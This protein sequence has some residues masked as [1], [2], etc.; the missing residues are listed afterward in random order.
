[1]MQR[2]MS[3]AARTV[4]PWDAHMHSF[5]KREFNPVATQ[6][7]VTEQDIDNFFNELRKSPNYKPK[8][9]VCLVLM[10]PLIMV[11]GMVVM[12][13]LIFSSASS[14]SSSSGPSSTIFL[15]FLMMPLMF[16]CMIGIICYA[17]QTRMKG[18]KNRQLEFEQICNVQNQSYFKAKECRW[19]CGR[20]GAYLTLELDFVARGL[21]QM[22][23]PGGFNPMMN[24]GFQPGF[25]PGGFAPNPGF[26]PGMAPPVNQMNYG[27]PP[28]QNINIAKNQF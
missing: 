1:M 15:P 2:P 7:R 23:Q 3:N 26:N 13:V 10:A 8:N 20:F 9:I 14:S 6:G 24:Q 22:G 27:A 25:N 19:T 18:L 12:M 5:S 28:I 21:A 16:C 4:F 17:S 11:V